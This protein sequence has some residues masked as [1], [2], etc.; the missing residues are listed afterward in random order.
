MSLYYGQRATPG[1]LLI[2]EACAVSEAA[3]GSPD[4]PG[5]WTDEQVDAWKPIVDAVH[6]KGAVFFAQ[7]WHAGRASLLGTTTRCAH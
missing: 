1:G 7:I 5:L 6:A 2:A 3:R 4:V